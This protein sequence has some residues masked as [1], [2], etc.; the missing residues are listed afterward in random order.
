MKLLLVQ[1]IANGYEVLYFDPEKNK[2]FE[3]NH[4]ISDNDID[5]NKYTFF[6]RNRGIIEHNI[7][8][9]TNTFASYLHI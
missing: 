8:P 9:P 2:W 4:N 3:F 7:Q 5:E 6:M 1:A